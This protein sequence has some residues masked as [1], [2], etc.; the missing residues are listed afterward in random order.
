MS[1]AYPLWLSVGAIAVLGVVGTGLAYVFQYDVVRAAGF[2]ADELRALGLAVEIVE[3]EGN[4]LV[5][6]ETE[7]RPDR[8]TLLI[9]G[10]YDVQPAD[11]LELWKTPPFEPTIRDGR[12]YA[13]GASDVKGSTLI[14][15]E[16]V[17]EVILRAP[18]W[19]PCR[20]T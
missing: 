14:A 9:Y 19:Q 12:I 2:L 17:I 13:R 16:T 7:Q 20:P 3:T 11:P 5:Y 4:P 15:V 1:D 6:A 18:P 8:K 10:H